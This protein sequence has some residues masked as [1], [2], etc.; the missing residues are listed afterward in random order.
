MIVAQ[1]TNLRPTMSETR[2]YEDF[3]KVIGTKPHML[4]VLSRMNPDLTTNFITEG[5]RNVFYNDNKKSNR[6]Q[7]IDSMYFDWEI[8]SNQIKKIQ[9]AEV[10][11]EVGT[12]G[13]EITMKF[14]ERWYEKYDI[15][16]IDKTR[17]QCIVVSRP[18]RRA[19]NCWEVQVR[20]V[21]NNYDTELD[22]EGC[23]IG[24][25]TTFQSNAVPEMSEE[26]Y[27][28]YQS[29]QILLLVIVR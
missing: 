6:F 3:Y 16:K 20:L 7:S 26:G 15:F 13:T 27:V 25:T 5:L 8:E 19:D 2:T 14:T 24:D 10:P 11:T 1:M 21:D 29:K 18:I 28:K 17:Q 12:D 9:F 22:L 4:G 23:Q